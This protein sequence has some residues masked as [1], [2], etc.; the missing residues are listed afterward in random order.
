MDLTEVLNLLSINKFDPLTSSPNE[1][2]NSRG[3]YVIALK[4]ISNLPVS[5]CQL[6]YEFIDNNPV[7]YTGISGK[8]G[9]RKRD[10]NNHFNGNA[11]GSTLRKSLGVLHGYEKIQYPRGIGSI[12]Y[13]FLPSDEKVL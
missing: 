4:S 6:Q 1:L 13:R 5:M 11:R 10:Y 8:Q 7:I 12:K 3:V 9:L 2:P